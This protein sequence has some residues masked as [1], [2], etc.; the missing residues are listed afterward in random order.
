MNQ[1]GKVIRVLVGQPEDHKHIRTVLEFD[2]G[3]KVILNEADMA[4]IARAFIHV[5][6]H[7]IDTT[8]EL[9][10]REVTGKPGFASYQLIEGERSDREIRKEISFLMRGEH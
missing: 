4:N 3:E 6:T 7:P 2:S 10:L 8:R 5:L 1:G 9:L